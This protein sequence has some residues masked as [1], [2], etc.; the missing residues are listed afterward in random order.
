MCTCR[1]TICP[2]KSWVWRYHR[3]TN[4][5][6]WAAVAIGNEI[7]NQF[8]IQK[9]IIELKRVI[10]LLQLILD[11]GHLRYRWNVVT[12]RSGWK[13]T[14]RPAHLV[15]D[16]DKVTSLNLFGQYYAADHSSPSGRIEATIEPISITECKHGA[17]VWKKGLKRCMNSSGIQHTPNYWHSYWTRENWMKV[18]AAIINHNCTSVSVDWQLHKPTRIKTHLAIEVVYFG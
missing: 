2:L 1:K 10:Y 4:I 12:A 8:P 7:D 16:T 15:I 13:K 6:H 17:L 5:S 3:W 18:R 9:L 11:S 14:A